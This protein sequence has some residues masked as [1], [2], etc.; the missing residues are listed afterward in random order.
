MSRKLIT[1]RVRDDVSGGFH[2]TDDGYL[3]E[4][5][6][7]INT[8]IPTTLNQQFRYL[9]L[10]EDA[11]IAEKVKELIEDYVASKHELFLAQG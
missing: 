10:L 11:S 2:R 4:D 9:L 5:T 8:Y 7:R 3:K 6:V 1:R